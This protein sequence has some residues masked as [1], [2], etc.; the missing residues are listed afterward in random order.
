MSVITGNSFGLIP[1]TGGRRTPTTTWLMP[2]AGWDKTRRRRRQLEKGLQVSL[3]SK[4]RRFYYYLARLYIEQGRPQEALTQI[5]RLERLTSR[6]L[7]SGVTREEIWYWK[8]V[9]LQQVGQRQTARQAFQR[10]A[11]GNPNYFAYLAA[12]KS[13]HR[14]TDSTVTWKREL[15]KPRSW[16]KNS[17]QRKAALS[18]APR[19]R[20]RELLFLGLYDQA[21]HQIRR[22]HSREWSESLQRLFNLAHYGALGGLARESLLAAEGLRRS[23][24][25]RSLVWAYPE[26]VARLLYPRHYSRY[27]DREAAALKLDPAFIFSVMH[28]ESR[29]QAQA[30]ST[31]S[32][33]GL[34]QF[35]LDTARGLASSLQLESIEADDLYEP[36]LS[37]QLGAHHLSRLL[38]EFDGSLER[39]LAGYNGGSRNARRWSNKIR[40]ADPALFVAN[41]GFRETKLYVL[42]VMGNYFAYRRLYGNSGSETPLLQTANSSRFAAENGRS[43]VDI[44]R[45]P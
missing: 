21:A 35:T 14:T 10:A 4:K 23:L 42:K 6:Q 34:M 33:R 18:S 27:V 24:G 7:P 26:P 41:I 37:I 32:A 9:C 45:I 30:K 2:T 3:G 31:A 39:A 25:R 19:G 22:T 17:D 8:G 38:Q 20:V 5:G 44:F 36:A 11:R 16:W 12:A 28:Q 29:F 15:E 40:T 1:A 43:S 13:S